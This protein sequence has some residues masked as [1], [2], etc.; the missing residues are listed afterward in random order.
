LNICLMVT[1]NLSRKPVE[2]KV[3]Y[4]PIVYDGFYKFQVSRSVEPS[5]VSLMASIPKIVTSLISTRPN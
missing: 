4:Y 2:G 1:R 3:G 5:T